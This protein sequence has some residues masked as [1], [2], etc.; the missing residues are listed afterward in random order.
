MKTI[1]RGGSM[2]FFISLCFS[3][4]LF[5][6]MQADKDALDPQSLNKWEYF[7]Q[8]NGLPDNY[9]WSLYEDRKGNIWIGTFNEGVVM[10]NG[11]TFQKYN[12]QNGLVD[13][14]VL[15]TYEDNEGKMWFGTLGG[16]SILDNN[17]FTN[18]DNIQGNPLQVFDIIQDPDKVFWFATSTLGILFYDGSNISQ[19]FDDN[20]D[21]CNRV[22]VFFMDDNHSIWVGSSGDLKVVATNGNFKKYTVSDGLPG[23]DIT[24]V[25]QDK[26]GNVWIGSADGSQVSRFS[27]NKFQLVSLFNSSEINYVSSIVQLN[28]GEMWF[29]TIALGLIYSDGIVMRSMFEQHGLPD[30]TITAMIKDGNGNIWIGTSEGGAAKFIPR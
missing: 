17:H 13:N 16:L 19:Y 27:N 4:G 6:C 18:I 2:K 30:N 15:C 23:L 25:Y 26:S 22:N 24:S 14:T 5:S 20:C 7:T 12:T 1:F 8:S 9:I 28:T 3:F 11:K 29:G 10:Y 21:D